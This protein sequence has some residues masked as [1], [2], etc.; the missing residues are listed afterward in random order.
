LAMLSEIPD[1]DVR[2]AAAIA[3]SS[4][5]WQAMADGR[6]PQKS[7]WTLGG[8]PLPYLPLHGERLLPQII[9]RALLQRL[10]WR[11][12]PRPLRVLPAFAASLRDRRAVARAA[13]RVER[14]AAPILFVVGDDDQMW[15]AAAML[16]TLRSR[17]RSSGYEEADRYLRFADTGH[18]IRP[19]IVPT[20]I[21]QTEAL[22]AGGTPAGCARANADAWQA[23]LTLLDDHLA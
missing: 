6:P 14:I 20:T 5:I 16:K 11:P 2:A 4:V 12:H 7:S 8:E 9:K 3:P 17:R 19:P 18:I 10:S 23:I 1:V 22:H 13:I 15:P 21:T